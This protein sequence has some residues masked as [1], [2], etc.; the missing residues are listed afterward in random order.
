MMPVTIGPEL[1]ADGRRAIVVAIGVAGLVRVGVAIGPAPSRHVGR[2]IVSVPPAAMAAIAIAIGV[3]AAAIVRIDADARDAVAMTVEPAPMAIEPSFMAEAPEVAIA[4][5][6]PGALEGSRPRRSELTAAAESPGAAHRS[7]A[8]RAGHRA[9]RRHSGAALSGHSGRP[10]RAGVRACSAGRRQRRQR[11]QSRRAQRDGRNSKSCVTHDD[12]LFAAR[13]A[14]GR[15]SHCEMM[16][17]LPWGR[18]RRAPRER[19]LSVFLSLLSL[20]RSA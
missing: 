8:A 4:V 20:R 15:P 11:S 6:H 7:A 19:L 2:I 10:L 16:R 18:T 5:A 9:M 14:A 12:L 13:R 3:V 1:E 17:L